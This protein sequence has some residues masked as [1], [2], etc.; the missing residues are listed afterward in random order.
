M[1]LLMGLP[2]CLGREVVRL[3]PDITKLSEGA[4]EGLR[5]PVTEKWLA[6]PLKPQSRHPWAFHKVDSFPYHLLATCLIL[7]LPEKVAVSTNEDDLCFEQKEC[8][9]IPGGGVGRH[10]ILIALEDPCTGI[11]GLFVCIGLHRLLV[12]ELCLHVFSICTR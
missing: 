7:F 1:T 9:E 12:Q 6:M 4:V 2:A 10:G 5:A 3:T 11:W 8:L